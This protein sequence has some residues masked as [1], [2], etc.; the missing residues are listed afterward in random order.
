MIEVR[1]RRLSE[2]NSHHLCQ[3]PATE[4][5]KLLPTISAWG[6]QDAFCDLTGEFVVDDMAAYFEVV[7]HD[8]TDDE[9]EAQS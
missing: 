7:V 6:I 2:A 9:P 5:D 4:L 8:E 1:I 3:W